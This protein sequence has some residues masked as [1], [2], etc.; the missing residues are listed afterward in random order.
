MRTH[1]KFQEA[2]ELIEKGYRYQRKGAIQQA[3]RIYK[4]SLK[5]LP[6]A[7][8]HT[9]LGWAFSL[10][11]EYKAAI[12]ECYLAIELDPDYGNPYNDLGYYFL[13]FKNY[14]K[15][16]SWFLKALEANRY[17]DKHIALF[18]L[19]RVYEL[20]GKWETAV[21]YYY[22]SFEKKPSFKDASYAVLRLQALLN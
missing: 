7:E 1:R 11:G 13:I 20:Q 4:A 9:H 22:Q 10:Q 8:G 5:V 2:F 16:I 6:T 15:A 21:E 19:G 12:Y 3:I 17:D 14:E 18:N